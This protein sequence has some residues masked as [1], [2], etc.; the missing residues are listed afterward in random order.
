MHACMFSLFLLY[1]M[2]EIEINLNI[3]QLFSEFFLE[4]IMGVG[5]HRNVSRVI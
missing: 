1:Q 5:L 3:L 2:L 4:S